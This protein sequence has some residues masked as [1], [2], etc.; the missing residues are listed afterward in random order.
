M[1]LIVM[2]YSYS[3][4]VYQ[5]SAL[6]VQWRQQPEADCELLYNLNKEKDFSYGHRIMKARLPV[7]SAIFKHDIAGLVLQWVTMRESPVL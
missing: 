7:R 2:G 1:I 6:M 3:Y 5:K 4:R